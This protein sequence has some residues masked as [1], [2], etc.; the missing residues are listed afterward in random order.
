MK[1]VLIA[2][3]GKNRELGKDNDL[4]W[5]FKKDMRFFRQTTT[6]HTVVMGRKTFDSLPHKLPNRHHVIISRGNP[7]YED[8]ELFHSIEDF[9][10]A[11]QDKDETVYGIGG[12]Q[13]Y[14]QLLPYAD[15]LLL[16]EIDAAA[17]AD[18]YFPAFDKEKYTETVLDVQEEDGIRVRWVSYTK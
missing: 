10:K 8:V 13:I 12:A 16:T 1:L 5:H 9:L 4:I 2:A 3:I 14:A 17:E 18:A 15:E 6:G 11:Y 7:D